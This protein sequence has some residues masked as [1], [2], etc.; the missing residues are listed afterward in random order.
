MPDAEILKV[1]IVTCAVGQVNRDDKRDDAEARR[2]LRGCARFRTRRRAAD[3]GRGRIMTALTTR[4][5]RGRDEPSASVPLAVR[6]A[7]SGA[8]CGQRM[9]RWQVSSSEPDRLIH[10]MAPL[11]HQEGA[12]QLPAAACADCGAREWGGGRGGFSFFIFFGGGGAAMPQLNE[13]V[14][15]RS[16]WAFELT[17]GVLVHIVGVTARKRAARIYDTSLAN[18]QGC[19]VAGERHHSGDAPPSFAFPSPAASPHS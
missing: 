3:T 5:R 2:E 19:A 14:A 4:D 13:S 1:P 18:S 17:P 8:A 6:E 15:S 9:E 16:R 11:A 7:V 12:P 10:L